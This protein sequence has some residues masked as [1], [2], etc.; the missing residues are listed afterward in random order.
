MGTSTPVVALQSFNQE[1]LRAFAVT[2]KEW[3][4]L[5]DTAETFLART[6]DEAAEIAETLRDELRVLI[7]EVSFP[8]KP[9]PN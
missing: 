3:L 5:I 6:R 1:P 2:R 4:P 7:G 8:L 9:G